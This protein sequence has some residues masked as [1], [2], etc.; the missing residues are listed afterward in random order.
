MRAR[1]ELQGCGP[2]PTNTRPSRQSARLRN[3]NAIIL[4]FLAMALLLLT[5][6]E[7]EEEKPKAGPP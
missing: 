2:E 1:P 3:R 5:G 4:G 7:K 6:C